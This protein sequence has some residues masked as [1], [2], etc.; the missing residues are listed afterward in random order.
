LIGDRL[1][2]DAAMCGRFTQKYTW[3][4]IHALYRLTNPAP[5]QFAGKLEYRANAG[6]G[7]GGAE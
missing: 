3:S 7:R 1:C 5:S 4:E 2:I 6:R